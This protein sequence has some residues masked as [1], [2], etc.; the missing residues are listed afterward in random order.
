M[1]FGAATSATS[2]WA[3]AWRLSGVAG[4]V[5]GI[6]RL[7][8]Q[9]D[10]GLGRARGRLAKVGDEGGPALGEARLLVRHAPHR[11]QPGTAGGPTVAKCQLE[12]LE[13]L[14]LAS[15]QPAEPALAFVPR[16]QVE[17]NHL[18]IVCPEPFPDHGLR[19]LGVRKLVLDGPEAPAG[20]RLEPVEKGAFGEEVAQVGGKAGHGGGMIPEYG[21]HDCV[22]ACAGEGSAILGFA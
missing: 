2:A 21:W 14:R 1:T 7:G 13:E 15:G 20:R 5:A 19:S 12:S 22:D 11:V 6:E 3:S 10:A 17:Q 16:R 18:Q 9:G 4:V 8:Q